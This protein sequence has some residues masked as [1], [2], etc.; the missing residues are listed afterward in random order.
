M[1]RPKPK[2]G[3]VLLLVLLVLVVAGT[4]LAAAARRSADNAVRAAAA[5]RDLQV[6]WGALSCRATLLPMAEELLDATAAA[7]EPIIQEARGTVFLGGMRFNLVL[8]DEQAKVNVGALAAKYGD[9][10]LRNAMRK[11]QA[12]GRRPLE[13]RLRPIKTSAD[14]EA[15]ACYVSLDQVFVLTHPSQWIGPEPGDGA[16]VHRRVTCWGS[17][18]INLKRA[19]VAT[20]REA[21]G[22]ALTDAQLTRLD[23]IRRHDPEA[24]LPKILPQLQLSGEQTA[25]VVEAATDTSECHSLWACVEDKTRQWYRLFVEETPANGT[26]KDWTYSW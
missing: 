26:A 6:H 14:S 17:G 23:D 16:V 19:E 15:A 3:Y 25:T 11:L 12:D 9:D 22:G 7:D 8:S 2:S 20:L 13:V 10:R 21:L 1:R 5:Q 24:G 4:V 18:R